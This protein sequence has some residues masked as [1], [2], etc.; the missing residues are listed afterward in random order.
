MKSS[1]REESLRR[2]AMKLRRQFAQ[3]GRGAFSRVLPM[4]NMATVL[5]EE[6][7]DYRERLF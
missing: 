6:C 5:E 4:A 3:G 7:G 2:E 1:N